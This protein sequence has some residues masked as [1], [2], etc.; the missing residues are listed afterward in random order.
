MVVFVCGVN[1]QG[2][3]RGNPAVHLCEVVFMEQV[4]NMSAPFVPVGP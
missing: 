1:Q 3:P 2:Y 4:L